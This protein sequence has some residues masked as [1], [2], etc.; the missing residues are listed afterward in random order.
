MKLIHKHPLSLLVDKRQEI[1]A[2]YKRVESVESG[3]LPGTG[4][5]RI[6]EDS[7]QWDL[8]KIKRALD[9]YDAAIDLLC[10]R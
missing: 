6:F 5:S 2:E 4:A 10:M 9:H 8:D 1:Y 3:L 7:R